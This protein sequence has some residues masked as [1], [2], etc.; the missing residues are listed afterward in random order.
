V[1]GGA[2][3]AVA[4][5]GTLLVDSGGLAKIQGT[6]LVDSG[7]LANVQGTLQVAGA[8]SAAAGSAMVVEQKGQLVVQAGANINF[9]GTLLKWANPSDLVQGT[10]LGSNQ[11]AATATTMVG[12]SFV[13]LP[14]SFNY[15][16]ASGTVLATGLAQPLSVTFTPNDTVLYASASAQVFINVKPGPGVSVV[17]TELWMVGGT[18]STDN[19]QVSPAGGSSTGSTGVLVRTLLNGVRYVNT[20]T[21]TFSAIRIFASGGN[22][23]IQLARTL[24]LNTF[25][26]AGNGNDTVVT[27]DGNN[28]IQLGNG[29]DFVQTGNGNDVITVGNGSDNIQTGNGNKTITAGNGNNYIQARTGTD[30]VSLGNGTN[31][32][33]LGDGANVV[34]LGN[35]NNQV[36]LGNGNNILVEGNGHDY[37][38][39]KNGNNLIVGGLGPHNISVGNGSNILIDGSVTLTQAGD[40]LSQ[41]LNDW[42]TYGATA[43]NIASIRARLAVTDNT[44]YANALKAGSGLDWFWYTYGRDSSNRKL[45]DLLN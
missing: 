4:S 11:L 22:E 41:I 24:T 12:G 27:G 28:T 7:G 42:T 36:Q 3:F 6:L 26:S 23:V 37:V 20:F 45:T 30:V 15:N 25:I 29:L 21:Q 9:A 31:Y 8:L 34:T 35:G 13:T 33:Q 39:A 40:S 43:S 18:T 1:A 32:V 10:P 5:A 38:V 14:G 16:P 44:A 17:G 2:T 19:I